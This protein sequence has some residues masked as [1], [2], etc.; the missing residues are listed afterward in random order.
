MLTLAIETATMQVGCA[1][2][3]QDGMLGTHEISRGRRHA[4]ALAPALQFVFQQTGR[5]F[6][7]VGCIAVDVGPGLFTG[8]RVGLATALAMAQSLDVPMVPIC[9][10]DAVAY[11]VRHTARLVVAVLD[12]RR[13]EVF[14]ASYRSD[15]GS[16]IGVPACSS[17]ED[18]AGQLAMRT[19][20][21][22]LVGDGAH[23]YFD[24]LSADLRDPLLA[25]AWLGCPTATA[26]AQLAQPFVRR[27][28]WIAPSS[29][30]P[31]Y[32][33]KPDAE[34]NWDTRSGRHRGD[35]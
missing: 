3:D 18:L 5:S 20:P 16:R 32:L 21:L 2:A 6:D 7:E 4:E 29:I 12:A 1:L 14:H 23:T 19:E 31:L 24:V 8:L 26:V 17:P 35:Q 13:G 10:L 15:D 9:S 27:E 30:V 25:D 34:I 28:E 11:P 22:L 33:R